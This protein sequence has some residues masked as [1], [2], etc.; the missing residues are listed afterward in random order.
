M[1]GDTLQQQLLLLGVSERQAGGGLTEE[2]NLQVA[3]F[4]TSVAP[5]C[6]RRFAVLGSTGNHYTV[7]AARWQ[8]HLVVCGQTTG[9]A[10]PRCSRPH[11]LLS[12]VYH[13]MAM[14]MWCW[15]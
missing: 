15:L 13:A 3:F 7:R 8:H 12:L 9:S 5:P 4:L 2:N 1:A 10:A 11:S 14:P 6:C